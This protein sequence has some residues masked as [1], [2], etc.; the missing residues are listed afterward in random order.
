MTSGRQKS[1]EIGRKVYRID[2]YKE[3]QKYWP[4]HHIL[5]PSKKFSEFYDTV[6]DLNQADREN[7]SQI[8]PK[9]T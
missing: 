6:A 2:D 4:L 5:Y 9:E 8:Q 1:E 7:Q 3:A